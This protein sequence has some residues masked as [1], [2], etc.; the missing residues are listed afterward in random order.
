MAAC[1][2]MATAFQPE[3]V[4]IIDCEL[5]GQVP[6][7]HDDASFQLPLVGFVQELIV[8]AKTGE[9]VQNTTKTNPRMIFIK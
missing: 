5:S 6:S 1:E 2:S 4:I 3:F 7:D 8:S 9:Q